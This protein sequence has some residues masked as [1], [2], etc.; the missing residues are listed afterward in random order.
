MQQDMIA[1]QFV[2]LTGMVLFLF[3][4]SQ[5]DLN[6]LSMIASRINIFTVLLSIMLVIM[7]LFLRGLRWYIIARGLGLRLRS[8]EAM[9]GLCVAQ[10]A[11]FMLPGALGDLIRVPYLKCRGN[12]TNTSIISVLIDSL[13]AAVFPYT[14]LAVSVILFLNPSLSVSLLTLPIFVLLLCGSYCV[15]HLL[16]AHLWSWLTEA[17]RVEIERTGGRGRLLMSVPLCIAM[18]GRMRLVLGLALSAATWFTYTVLAWQ[19]GMAVGIFIPWS[20]MAI[21]ATLASIFSTLPISVQG[22]GVREGVFLIV[23]SYWGLNPE[24]VVTFSLLLMA[25]SLVPSLWGFI[26]WQRDPFIRIRSD[27]LSTAII[28]PGTTIE[29]Y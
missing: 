17:R 20:M 4:L 3:I 5:I 8:I 6:H 24:S 1:N 13:L 21:A 14:V 28:E 25:T 22:L 23:M 10:M 18:L 9:D 15:Y 19:L 11:S 2:R 29:E 27:S 7:I 26:S 12:P 16:K